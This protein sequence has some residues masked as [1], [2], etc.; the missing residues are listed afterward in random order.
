MKIQL[1]YHHHITVMKKRRRKKTGKRNTKHMNYLPKIFLLKCYFCIR[2]FFLHF[3]LKFRLPT[4]FIVAQRLVF[5]VLFCIQYLSIFYDRLW[6]MMMETHFRPGS[7]SSIENI[8]KMQNQTFNLTSR[9][10]IVLYV[11]RWYVGVRDNACF[12]NSLMEKCFWFVKRAK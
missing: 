9:P 8:T 2:F 10:F 1:S 6:H 12:K 3:G 4:C 5:C 7:Y 11:Y